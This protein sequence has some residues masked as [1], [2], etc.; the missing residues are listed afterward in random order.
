MH[1]ICTIRLWFQPL[2]AAAGSYLNSQA[3]GGTQQ[4]VDD[5]FGRIG[6]GEHAAIGFGF[7][8]HTPRL[9]PVDGIDG[10]EAS[11]QRTNPGV[12]PR[13]VGGEFFMVETGV[14]HVA[15]TAPGDAHF[16][17]HLSAF[18]VDGY[19]GA[20]VRFGSGNGPE[21]SGGTPAHHGNAKR[22][23]TGATRVS[24]GGFG[25][26]PLALP[27]VSSVNFSP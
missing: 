8:R 10:I 5:G 19:G 20:R 4:A 18:F 22:S 12:A 14:G 16:L 2:N 1:Y 23:H 13:V 6:G 15:A 7:Q 25:E 17:Q 26:E 24:V 27:H 3:A 9:E 21:K 11:E